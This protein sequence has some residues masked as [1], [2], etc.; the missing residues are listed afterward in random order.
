LDGSSRAI[1]NWSFDVTIGGFAKE[2][3]RRKAVQPSTRLISSAEP[4]LASAETSALLVSCGYWDDT[5]KV[6]STEGFRLLASAT[7]GHR[8]EICCLK[9]GQDG[10]LMVTG[11]IDGTCR[12]WVIDHPDMAIA[13]SDGY[14]QTALGGSN[15]GQQI[16]SCCH[17]LWGHE[18]AVSCVDLCVELDAVASGSEE[19][20]VAIHTIR[21]GDFIRSFRPRPVS[22]DSSGAVSKIVLDSTGNL[23]VYMKDFGL[24]M[25][26]VNGTNLCS[27][28]AGEQLHDMRMCSRGEF[29][30]TGGEQ[31]QV[32]IRSVVNLSVCAML[33]LSSHGPIRCV[34]LTP[35]DLNPTQQYLFIGSDDGMI[36]IVDDPKKKPGF[37]QWE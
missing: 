1:G 3:L 29:L 37:F 7:G 8:G 16:L 19:G 23:A 31:G 27:I 26:T 33:D 13:L 5:V 24:H 10:G 14:V 2:E 4:T 12:V 32:L 36:S 15:D 11:G 35:D 30:V 22:D 20:L 9:I 18:S 6:H 21:R 28:D 25:Y 34:G 17:V